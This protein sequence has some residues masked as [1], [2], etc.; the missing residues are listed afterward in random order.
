M[1]RK[2]YKKNRK[3]T[4]IPKN[5]SAV[6]ERKKIKE[7]GNKHQIMTKLRDFLTS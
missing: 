6:P 5:I 3:N 1:D 2:K 7:L 4:K